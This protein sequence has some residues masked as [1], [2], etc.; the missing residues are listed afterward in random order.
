MFRNF[1]LVVFALAL[2]LVAATTAPERSRAASPAS[3]AVE[4]IPE[5][6]A[7]D[8]SSD[9]PEIEVSMLDGKKMK[10]SSLRGKVCVI[11]MF[12]SWCPHC[13]EHAPQMVKV[14]NQFKAQG[15]EMVSLA[16]DQKDRIA[17]VRKFVKD[18]SLNYPVGFM[19]VEVQAYYMDSH[20]HNIPQVLIFGK[21]GKMVKRWI[22]W[23]DERTTELTSLVEGELKKAAPSGAAVAEPKSEPKSVTAPAKEVPAKAVAAKTPARRKK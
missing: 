17:D 4:E 23:S 14:Y 3:P 21:D 15:F 9:T 8:G 7:P 16:T 5:L 18:Y 2:L 19:T 22:G 13:Q 1:T 11:D 10:L 12:A 6:P 20:S